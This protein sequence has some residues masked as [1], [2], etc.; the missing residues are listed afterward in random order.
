M[1]FLLLLTSLQYIIAHSTVHHVMPDNNFFINRNNNTSTLRNY[2]KNA[3][4]YFTSDTELH[5][6]PGHYQ[7]NTVIFITNTNNFSITGNGMN[8]VNIECKSSPGGIVVTNSSN[9]MIKGISLTGCRVNVSQYL[10][11]YDNAKLEVP[12]QCMTYG[13]LI[14]DTEGESNL[15]RISINGVLV[16][17]SS[18]NEYMNTRI[19]HKMILQNI[20]WLYNQDCTHRITLVLLNHSLSI[21][22]LIDHMLF[23]N[24]F[25]I[26]VQDNT[27]RGQNTVIVSN[28]DF[29]DLDSN[30]LSVHKKTLRTNNKYG[31]VSMTVMTSYCT[32]S[33]SSSRIMAFSNS[34][35]ANNTL[36]GHLL[37]LYLN[38]T[39]HSVVY[40]DQC[41]FSNN[42]KAKHLRLHSTSFGNVKCIVR[43]VTFLQISKIYLI[44]T[45]KKVQLI[46]KGFVKFRDIQSQQI[47][48]G[49]KNS[50]FTLH[51]YIE[52]N[53]INATLLV[54]SDQIQLQ[55][56]TLIKI[57]NVQCSDAIFSYQMETLIY[58]GPK[59]SFSP[60][61]PPCLFQYQSLSV[62]MNKYSIL[63]K[64]IHVPKLCTKN[65]C[66][67][68][69]SLNGSG[70]ITDLLNPWQIN[71]E[72]IKF[73]NK[74]AAAGDITILK[75]NKTICLCPDEQYYNC[76]VDELPPVYPGQTL[77]IHLA[78]KFHAEP[79]A[80]VTV[81]LNH[82]NLPGTT[83]KV[84]GAEIQ[85][86]V[87]NTCS[88]VHYTIH[89]G[90]GNW[91][92]IF[93]SQIQPKYITELYPTYLYQKLYNV[94]YVKLLPCPPGFKMDEN[95]EICTCDPILKLAFPNKRL[96]CDINN[97]TILHPGNIWI[98]VDTDNGIHSYCVSMSCQFEYCSPHSSDINLSVPDSQ[99]QFSRTGVLCGQC[100]Q[101]LSVV[102][103]SSKCKYCSDVYLLIAIPIAIAGIV[104]VVFLF[105]FNLTIS[106]GTVNTFIFFVN[107]VNINISIFIPNHHSPLLTFLSLSNLDLGIETCFYNGMTDYTK[108]WLQ[109]AFPLYLFLIA[110]L[111]IVISRYSI[112][113]QRMTAQRVLPVLATLFLLSYTKILSTICSVLFSYRK[114]TCV[115]S[116]IV[117]YVWPVD[118]S[119]TLFGFK[120][121][122]IFVICL[123]LFLTLLPFNI[124][125]LF[126]RRLSCFE[127]INHFKPLLDVYY[128]P[129]NDRFYYWTGL[130]L[131]IRKIVFFLSLF[132]QDINILS[133]IVLL[134]VLFCL[135]GVANPYI[136]KFH[137][138][139]EALI[140]LILLAAHITAFYDTG[141]TCL[142]IIQLLTL[143]A[144]IYLLLSISIECFMK[145]RYGKV[146]KNYCFDH[147]NMQRR[148]NRCSVNEIHPLS[149]M[150]TTIVNPDQ[151]VEFQEPLLALSN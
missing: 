124:V 13:I 69:C 127:A 16:V 122:M 73:G 50:S 146:A 14:V 28:C 55:R 74:I 68:H 107:I 83:C 25:A 31:I 144:L 86:I 48:I 94:F 99:C 137:N 120:F 17:Y 11:P 138:I 114:L 58:E 143:I 95:K 145:S 10:T 121:A 40:I 64:D 85:Q 24:I 89:F 150:S 135:Q 37:S 148:N 70:V 136:S 62:E 151:C 4:K 133:V 53:S 78:L 54:S 57:T 75:D 36:D 5:F 27:C 60:L 126:S 90:H 142:A 7:L 93:L 97:H 112:K 6:L 139:Q 96:Q 8:E 131:V 35:F 19:E 63:L 104:L 34:T 129:Y 111:L 106:I 81:E 49:I 41:M 101:N 47:L 20:T 130:Q 71:R 79:K 103:G 52:F 12:M 1:Y 113:I 134:G 125:L 44:F 38:T 147:L 66:F 132:S 119:V 18:A 80:L 51:G 61:Y 56:N 82:H 76:L 98:S 26:Y 128:S 2:V 88:R 59:D 32:A 100:Q 43:N 65:F 67:S 15:S 110:I 105:M 140:L 23:R 108:T 84:N 3:N 42:I 9:V 87:N 117:T 46:F 29:V 118:T 77:H 33:M 30:K 141:P 22:I 116:Q 123:L 39:Q 45:L 72:V 115:P 109:L 21:V 91:C 149:N 92:E 102:F